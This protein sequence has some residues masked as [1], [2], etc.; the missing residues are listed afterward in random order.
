MPAKSGGGGAPEILAALGGMAP[1]SRGGAGAGRIFRRFGR[2]AAQAAPARA[3]PRS[4]QR[5]PRSRDCTGPGFDQAH[6]TTPCPE[7]LRCACPRRRPE[8]GRP[9]ARGRERR[10]AA[11]CGQAGGRSVHARGIGPPPS[12]GASWQSGSCLPG[13]RSPPSGAAFSTGAILGGPPISIPAA[14]VPR[15][16]L[17]PDKVAVRR[18]ML[19]RVRF[20]I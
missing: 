17:R 8:C 18:Y 7:A 1:G 20:R 11:G 12:A 3:P 4:R 6:G 9:A 16:A 2:G 10:G 19:E 15:Q 5:A 14:A 13:S